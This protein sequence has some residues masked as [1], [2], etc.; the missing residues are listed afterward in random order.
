MSL[1]RSLDLPCRGCLGPTGEGSEAGLCGRCWSGLTPLDPLRCSRCAL[2]HGGDC[3]GDPPWDRGDALWDYHGG[4]PPFGAMLVPGIKAGEAG[5]RRALL[6]RLDAA[7]LPDWAAEAEV[8]V[9]LPTQGWRRLWRG[10]DLAEEAAQPV[11]R[12]L[13]IPFHR[14]LRKTW[15]A[16]SQT[17][18]SE[19]RRRRLPASAFALKN[20]SVWKGRR[21]LLMDDVW[22]TGT[23]LSRCAEALRKAGA[24][25]DVLALFR[26]LR[27]G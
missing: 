18:H 22:T 11:A 3:E 17:G 24:Q 2:L 25:V 23:S 5:W 6:G 19:S 8:V 12:R 10:F 7:L 15:R 13:G 1:P 27:M 26:A 21:V 4:R 20:P 9:P 14:A 16:P